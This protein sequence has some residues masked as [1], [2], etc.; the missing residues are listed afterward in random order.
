MMRDK[1]A[2]NSPSIRRVSRSIITKFIGPEA[3]SL[4]LNGVHTPTAA[5]PDTKAMTGVSLEH[6]ID[7][8]GDQSYYFSAVR[9][10]PDVKGLKN[11]D[12]K[13][14]PVGAAPADRKS[15]RLNYSH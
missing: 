11:D 10:T 9:S 7:P 6:A 15:T 4:W 13:S 2:K 14:I 5:K 3:R 1:I 8:I 12:A